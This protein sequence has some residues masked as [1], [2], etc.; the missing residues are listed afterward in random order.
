MKHLIFTATAT[1]LLMTHTNPAFSQS[2]TVSGTK[3]TDANGNEFVIRGVNNPHVWYQKQSL[4]ALNRIAELRANCIRIVWQTYGRPGQLD[5]VLNRCVELEMIPMIELHDATGNPKA[6]KLLETVS[7]FKKPEVRSVLL[8][9][10]KYVLINLANEWGDYFITP[11]Y[12]K[13]S[14]MQAIKLLRNAGIKSTLVIDGPAW[15]QKIQPILKYGKEMIENDPQK[16]LLF[17][18][19]AYYLWNSPATIDTALKQAHDASLPLIIGEFGYNFNNGKNNLECKVDHKS[20]LKKCRELGIGYLAW[21][22]A[23]NDS[24]NSWLDLS[25]WNN[26]SWWGKEIFN[27]ENGIKSTAKKASVFKKTNSHTL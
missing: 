12:W 24:I 15:G 3:L 13:I 26:L 19:H 5:T 7:Y 10:E 9:Y 6:E 4:D 2:F 25:D 1:F 11:E 18:V 17:S 23:G 14:Y 20:L 27:G 8:K 16:N 22:W 21:S